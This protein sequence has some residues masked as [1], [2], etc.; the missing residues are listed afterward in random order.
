MF[1]YIFL[2]TRHVLQLDGIG[3][4]QMLSNKNA[5]I[6]LDIYFWIGLVIC[7]TVTVSDNK[8]SIGTHP[9]KKV[10]F[11]SPLRDNLMACISWATSPTYH[12]YLVH[13]QRRV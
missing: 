4:L 3:M 9:Q 7:Y 13:I 10:F 2:L 8:T 12:Q 5:W 6:G 11:I 1:F